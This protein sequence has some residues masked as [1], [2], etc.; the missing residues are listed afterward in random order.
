ME[1][2]NFEQIKKILD[3]ELFSENESNPEQFM[4]EEFYPNADEIEE[5]GEFKEEYRKLGNIEMVKHHGG[6]GQGDNY[7]TVCYFKDHDVYIQFQGWYASHHGSEYS[8]MFEVK[9]KQITIT[10]YKRV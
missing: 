7:Y 5:E 4:W 8:E 3:S 6:E 1:K 2:L 10:K 9:P